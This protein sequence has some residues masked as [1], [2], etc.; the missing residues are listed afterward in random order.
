A[1]ALGLVGARH[2]GET[3]KGADKGVDGRLQFHDEPV[4]GKTKEIIISVKA[5]NV[6]VS[7]VRDL[8]GVI[9]REGAEIGVV[10]SFEEPTGPMRSEAASAGFYT[11]PWGKHPHIQ[12]L[13]ISEL[14]AG[15]RIDYP[16]SN[17]TF[18]QAERAQL[19]AESLPL[20]FGD[21]LGEVAEPKEPYDS[22]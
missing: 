2:A 1:W 12:L 17:A 11:S 10:I 7:H 4:G 19:E 9:D 3:K 21:N 16:P 8:R 15:K 6:T 14:L 18:R 20:P 5:G 13:T 22:N